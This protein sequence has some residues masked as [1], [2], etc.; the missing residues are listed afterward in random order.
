MS[1][2]TPPPPRT[3]RSTVGPGLLVAAL[4]ALLTTLA[5]FAVDWLSEGPAALDRS[6]LSEL[7]DAFADE[8]SFH[9]LTETFFGF[10]WVALLVVAI[11]A[12]AVPFAPALRIPVVVACLVGTGWALFALIDTIE[13]ISTLDVGA[14]L[15]VGGPLVAALGA[16]LAR[17]ARY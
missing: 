7:L 3:A 13:E 17:T 9:I 6:D 2:T 16:F 4:G 1:T 11:A 10:G 5:M 14:Y 15:V 12:M 8:D